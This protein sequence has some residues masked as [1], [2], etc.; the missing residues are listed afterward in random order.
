MK[1]ILG[2]TLLWFLVFTSLTLAAEVWT[3][4]VERPEIPGF[5]GYVPD[6]IVVNFDPSFAGRMNQETLARGITGI[7]AL[8][9]V[10]RRH[11]VAR[12][13]R[14]FPGAKSK[15]YK[16]KK[17]RMDGWHRIYFKREVDI[18]EV[19]E[20]YNKIP[21]VI[22]AQPVS[23]HTVYR[24]PEEQFYDLQWHLPRIQA[25]QAWDTETGNSDIV[26]AILDTGVRYFQKD[27][28]GLNASYFD[29]THAE[30]NMWVNWSEKNG[31]D[32]IDDDGNGYVDDWIGWDFV[33][34]TY[35][36]FY[37]CYEGEDC[38]GADNDPRDFN[39]HGTHCAGIVAAQN[40]NGEAVASVA[41]GWGTGGLE[42]VGNGV[43]IM[44]LRIG[45]SI[46]LFGLP[47]FEVGVVE[48]D[49]A[50]EA[51]YY[52]A[53]NGAR[54]AS[55][56]WGSENTGGIGAAID[57]FLA[58]G[59]LIFKAAGN[60]S[61]STPDYMGSR[62]DIINVAA[63]DESDCK[64]EFS[65]YGSW[66]DI[67][68]PGVEIWSLFHD[69]FDPYTDYVAPLDG[70]S[71]AAPLAASVAALIWSQNPSWSAEEVKQ[72]LYLSADPIDGLSCNSTYAGELGAGRIN[73]YQAV[74]HLPDAD[75]SADST[76]GYNSL[77]VTFT[78]ESKGSITDWSWDFD[79]DGVEDSNEQNPTYIYNSP[80]IYTVKLEVFNEYGS[81][82]EE[83]VNFI[84]VNEPGADIN[85]EIG[86]V[87][88]L[89]HT[90]KQVN[91]SR[92]FVDPVVV[93]KPISYYGVDPAVV[94]MR[95]VDGRGF[96][97][98]V[99]EWNYLNG[100]HDV[101]ETVSYVVM[102]SGSHVLGDGT[103]VEAGSFVTNFT[104]SFYT[105]GFSESFTEA[106]VVAAAVASFN[107]TEA[108]T[109]RLQNI[110]TG[111][112]EFRMQEQERN[113]QSHSVETIHYIAWEPGSG[114]VNGLYF[115][116]ATTG[117]VVTEQFYRISFGSMITE[118]PRFL[119]DMQ[120]TNGVDPAVVRWQNRDPY[121]IEVKIE[122]E[123]SLDS[124]TTHAAEVVGY[125][126]FSGEE[127][128]LQ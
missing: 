122:E 127:S 79:G 94:R 45:W 115:E 53:E 57:Y 48:M 39:G 121:G 83:K 120:T 9:D 103:R 125:M 85:M 118:E 67:A 34:D 75:F 64:A 29:P 87:S 11:G 15:N 38:G 76:C 31:T 74:H 117:N 21:G 40:N 91:F 42:P 41:G 100:E 5:I 114:T 20:N 73:A 61:S 47:E 27:L 105:V 51:L 123:R 101:T 23:I 90:W 65:N 86:E 25:P 77:E 110:T 60:D 63:T 128:P 71:M 26:V 17:T 56:S 18:L 58:S 6:R 113:D 109:D 52:A 37:P 24:Q 59:G 30:G 92:C 82:V 96:E 12:I 49:Y 43:R 68:A 99:Q 119:A 98:R 1:R 116:V 97:I 46:A 3:V 124:E 22:N 16:G 2:M 55:C 33:E 66:V 7:A 88:G 93:A 108:V 104:S 54:I 111:S 14:L 81:D 4:D 107:G 126:A 84:T 32:G 13:K 80:G 50:A 89:D 70:T 44:P 28:G 102:E 19:V 72:M 36:P 10:G 95:N 8:D 62:D 69:H 35:Y 112:F 106:P 78:D